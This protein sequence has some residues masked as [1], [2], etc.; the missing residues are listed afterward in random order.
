MNKIIE[1]IPKNKANIE[2]KLYFSLNTNKP[3]KKTTKK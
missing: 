1:I 2:Y 3:I